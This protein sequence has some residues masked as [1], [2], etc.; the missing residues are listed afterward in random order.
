[1]RIKRALASSILALG[2]AAST[3]FAA[4]PV[5]TN[6]AAAKPSVHI[7][8]V[9]VSGKC[10]TIKVTVKNFKLVKPIY[11]PPIPKL[12]GN[13]G[14]IH[15]TLN[16]KILPTR[17]ATT[18]QSHT[19]CGSSEFVKTGVNVVSVYLATATHTMFPGTKP[20]TRKVKV[21]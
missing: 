16:G 9:T 15:Y 4:G 13:Q 18:K 20:S 3:L 1:M 12:K 6:A 17:D 21:K 11:A 10:I 5:A 7:T 8:S 19:F 14:H 2:F